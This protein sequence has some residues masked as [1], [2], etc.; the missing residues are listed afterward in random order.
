MYVCICNAIN[1][2]TVR[3]TVDEGAANVSGVFKSLAKTPQC[4]RCF[5][6]MRDIIAE[7][8]GTV[9]PCSATP[10]AVAAE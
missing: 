6:T 1:C 9:T 8:R 7:Q 4:G 10:M 5:S 3:R 2:R